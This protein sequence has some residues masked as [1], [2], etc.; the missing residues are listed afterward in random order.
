MYMVASEFEEKQGEMIESMQKL[1]IQLSRALEDATEQCRELTDQTI[2]AQE[3]QL[4]RGEQWLA[5]F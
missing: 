5:C 2:A 1:L 4:Q 3:E